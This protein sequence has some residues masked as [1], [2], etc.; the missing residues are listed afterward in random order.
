MLNGAITAYVSQVC[1]VDNIAILSKLQENVLIS[2]CNIATWN[3]RHRR[4]GKCH[5]SLIIIR[6][7]E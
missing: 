4:A 3:E 6:K 7:H 2:I 5:N 1:R